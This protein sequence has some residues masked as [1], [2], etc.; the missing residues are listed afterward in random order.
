MNG[1]DKDDLG[2][3]EVDDEKVEDKNRTFYLREQDPEYER[4]DETP[5]KTLP[6]LFWR[7]FDERSFA[8]E[9]A[10]DVGHDVVEDDDGDW[11]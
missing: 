2:A 11:K 6:G 9:K 8:E 3:G 7:Q 4:G 10:E 5:D 1:V